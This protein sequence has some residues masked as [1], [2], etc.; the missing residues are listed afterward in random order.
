MAED[1]EHEYDPQALRR[2]RPSGQPFEMWVAPR[3]VPAFVDAPFEGL[4]ASLVAALTARGGRFVDVGAHLGFYSLAVAAR[5]PEIEVIAVEPAPENVEVL[6]RNLRLH[7]IDR[8]RVLPAAASDEEGTRT[9]KIA[10]AS[11]SC[12]FYDHHLA[13]TLREVEVRTLTLDALLAERPDGA[14]LPTLIKIDTEGH[15]LQVLDGLRQTLAHGHTE[16]IVEFNPAMLRRAGA[17]PE[18]LLDRLAGLGLAVFV[19]DDAARRADRLE[20]SAQWE[21]LLAGRTYA[22]LYCVPRERALSVALFSHSAGFEGAE[23]TLAE[24]VRELVRDHGAVCTVFVPGEGQL[25]RELRDAGAGVLAFD[26]GWWADVNPVAPEEAE[27]RMRGGLAR[28]ATF[29]LPDLLRIRPDVIFTNTLV[30]PWG[31]AAAA[32]CGRPHVWLVS[33]FGEFPFFYPR[34]RVLATV[35]RGSARVLTASDA[36]RRELFPEADPERFALFP[37]A[38]ETPPEIARSATPPGDAPFRRPGALRLGVF[39][40]ITELKAQEVAVRALGE[41]TRRGVD[42]E[43]LLAGRPTEPYLGRVRRAAEE[44]GVVDRLTIAGILPDVFAALS[45]SDVVVVTCPREGFGRAAVEGMLLER[46]VV[47]PRSGGV[48]EIVADGET[49]LLYEP[50]D[51]AGLAG[52]VQ[53]LLDP[54]RRQAMGRAGRERARSRYG[55]ET[56]R[57][58]L[59]A[60]L[61]EAAGAAAP[62]FPE[63]L[64]PLLPSALAAGAEHLLERRAAWRHEL[65]ELRSYAEGLQGELRA[66]QDELDRSAAYVHALDAEIVAFHREQERAGDH[67]HKVESAL[68]QAVA[69]IPPDPGE[70]RVGPVHVVIV[71]HRGRELLASC[72]EWLLASRGVDLQ[73]V[74]VANGCR[75]PL[76]AIVDGAGRDPR[77]HALRLAEPVGFSHANNLGVAW[78]REWLGRPA[79]YLFLN[80]D[81]GVEPDA[82][83]ILFEALVA[84]ERCGVAGPRLVIWGAEDH[85]NSLGLNVTTIGEAWDEGIGVALADYGPLPPRREVLAVTGSAALVR[86]ETLRQIGGWNKIYGYYMEDIDLCLKARW[87]GWKVVHVPEAT[88][89]H[90]ISA[91]ADQI[92]DFKRLLSWRNQLVL[93][94]VHWPAGLLLRMAPR[95]LGGQAK[96]FVQRLRIR[97]Y[98]DARLQARAW[99]GALALLPRAMRQRLRHRGGDRSWTRFLRPAGSVPVI[100]LPAI[101]AGRRP[102]ERPA[103]AVE[104]LEPVSAELPAAVSERSST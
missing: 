90:A 97:C 103:V 40:T 2:I 49:G 72:L 15:E 82:I 87:H 102:W 4:T 66:R 88:V 63:P 8:V 16:L 24:M 11:D 28:L 85:L 37:P 12:G 50:G 18:A 75:E 35:P 44:E 32:L 99:R 29:A 9:F 70:P 5:H 86:E 62:P 14:D 52:A 60:L 67:I 84:D 57:G 21:E 13:E 31:A 42:A 38:L 61:R 10:R 93:I 98:A 89:A 80:N 79:A 81:A 34:E 41:L 7:G 68:R 25:A 104:R 101:P 33:E 1:F 20:R 6:E 56:W 53:A 73:V 69:R 71:H 48:A 22:N 27:R 51:A 26:Y 47:A 65:G 39:G 76:P 55:A 92:T 95:L 43:L 45:Q 46:P 77:V 17:E 91:T 78:A 23:Q 19:L 36:L 59:W 64:L 100:R 83:R 3:Y 96:A 58:R 74:I 54:E 30:I 94:L